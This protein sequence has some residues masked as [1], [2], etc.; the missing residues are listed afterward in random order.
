MTQ[1]SDMQ[2]QEPWVVLVDGEA[3]DAATALAPRL[4][5]PHG[6]RQQTVGGAQS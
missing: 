5:S 6:G 3:A 2:V 4:F 1:I